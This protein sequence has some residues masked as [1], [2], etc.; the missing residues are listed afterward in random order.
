MRIS[1]Y[2]LVVCLF[3]ACSSINYIGIETYNP[4]EITFPKDVKRVLIVNNAVAQPENAGYLYKL[5]GTEQ[6]TARAKADSA[7]YDACESMGKLIADV[8]FF[9]DVLLYHDA[10]RTDGEYLLDKKLSAGEVKELCEETGTDAII[11]FDRLLF[12]MDK[13]IVAFSEGFVRGEIEVKI[14][15]VVRAYLPTRENPLAAILINDSVFWAENASNLVQLEYYLPEPT[16]ALRAAGRYIGTNITPNFVPH[17]EN[18]T[19]WYYGGMGSRWKEASAYAASDNWE[20]ASMRWRHLYHNSSNWKERARAASNLALYYEMN[21]QLKEAYDWASKSYDLYEKKK[22][23]KDE[24]TQLQKLYMGALTNRL[25]LE[26]KL[27]MQFGE[28]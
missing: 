7:L 20:E 21:T 9:E 16:E 1:F 12:Q 22:G 15:G 4:A 28:D 17:W 24:Y 14:T 2:L 3:S 6:D 13:H 18:E 26:E 23:D 5:F 10:V 19:R 11:S 27:N 8:P 25:R